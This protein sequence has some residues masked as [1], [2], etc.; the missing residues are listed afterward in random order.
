MR[1]DIFSHLAE[2]RRRVVFCGACWLIL[3]LILLPFS[4]QVWALIGQ[5]MMNALPDGGR[6]ISVEVIGAFWVPLKTTALVSLLA[7]APV[8]CY[9]AW[10]FAAPGLF[11]GERKMAGLLAG[12]SLTLFY[13]GVAFA[14]AVALPAVYALMAKTAPEGVSVMTD[15]SRH[16]DFVISATLAFGACFQIPVAMAIAG[17]AGIVTARQ[18]RDGRGYATVAI[19]AVAAVATPPDILSQ[20]MLAVPMMALYEIGIVGAAWMRTHRDTIRLTAT[21]SAT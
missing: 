20:F 10:K 18:L 13:S 8:F 5:P 19:F 12:A 9:H 3:T 2:L 11:P 7:C 14:N 15:I 1:T 16:L 21:E 4:E 6:A 17:W